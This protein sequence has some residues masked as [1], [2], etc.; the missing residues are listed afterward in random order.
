MIGS[1]ILNWRINGKRSLAGFLYPFKGSLFF[2]VWKYKKNEDL[3]EKLLFALTIPQTNCH[4][5]IL[6]FG[7]A[8]QL[9]IQN[10]FQPS[11]RFHFGTLSWQWV[12]SPLPQGY[13]VDRRHSWGCYGGCWW[14]LVILSSS[15]S[16]HCPFLWNYVLLPVDGVLR[17]QWAGNLHLHESEKPSD[18]CKFIQQL[19]YL[20][21]STLFLFWK[22]SQFSKKLVEILSSRRGKSLQK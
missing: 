19:L 16:P 10:G 1:K 17:W 18:S 22:A 5:Q 12:L 2:R 7:S 11:S 9:W 21:V 8:Y 20:L 14:A 3:C 13:E 4:H 15:K 6:C